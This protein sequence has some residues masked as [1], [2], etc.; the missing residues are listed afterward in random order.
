MHSV[1]GELTD[2][3]T[4]ALAFP[5]YGLVWPIG[6]IIGP[7]LGGTFSH[8]ADNFPRLFDAAL[9]RSVSSPGT[10]PC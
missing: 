2:A 8:P 4:Q 6:A 10:Q 3:S 5:I 1:L 9:F 7:L